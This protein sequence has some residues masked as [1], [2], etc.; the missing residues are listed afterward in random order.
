MRYSVSAAARLKGDFG[1]DLRFTLTKVEG[2]GVYPICGTTWAVL[3]KKHPGV[4][5]QELLK[6]LRW[7]VHE[8]QEYA[9]ALHY[10]PLPPE[11]VKKIDAALAEVNPNP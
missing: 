9:P 10:A 8:G 5:R 3:Y 2:P 6:F 1:P 11:L 4:D 7:A